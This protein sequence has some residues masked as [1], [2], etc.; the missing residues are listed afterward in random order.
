M[1]LLNP[2]TAL[3]E[4]TLGVYYPGCI[5]ELSFILKWFLRPSF[6]KLQS[7]HLEYVYLYL[8]VHPWKSENSFGESVFSFYSVELRNWTGLSGLVTS[9]FIHWDVSLGPLRP[10]LFFLMV[11]SFLMA[12]LLCWWHSLA[13]LNCA[14]FLQ[15][16][17]KHRFLKEP[18]ISVTGLP[19]Q[20]ITAGGM[21]CQP[22]VD[23]HLLR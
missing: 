3:S 12:Q 6:F 20:C 4:I 2:V 10:F 21:C 16:G 18:G 14:S 9:V 1:F 13:P 7:V 5:T 23:F 19:S 8:C 11:V 22:L 15:R 17:L